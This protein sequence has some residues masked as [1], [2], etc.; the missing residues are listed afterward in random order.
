MKLI[1]K[2]ISN[3]SMAICIINFS[4]ISDLYCQVIALDTPHLDPIHHESPVTISVTQ[5]LVWTQVTVNHMQRPCDP[6][7]CMDPSHHE[8]PV[9]ISVTQDLVWTQV[10]VNHM[11]PSV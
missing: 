8:S 6:G 7:L 4:W 1:S 3:L 11:Q 2:E 9:T 10:T 5:D